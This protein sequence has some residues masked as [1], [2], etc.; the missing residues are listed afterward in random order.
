MISFVKHSVS[1][2]VRS[3]EFWTKLHILAV[4]V[5]VR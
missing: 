2:A 3:I 5:F 4:H 1:K